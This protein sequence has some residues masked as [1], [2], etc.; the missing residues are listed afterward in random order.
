MTGDSRVIGIIGGMGPAATVEFM[1][2]VVRR[3]DAEDDDGHFRMLVDNNPKVPSRI[4]AIIEGT[5]ADPL[6][7]LQ[8]MAAGLE[9][10]G[11]DFLVMPCN[12]AHHYHRAIADAVGIPF[13]SIVDV[14][15][16]HLARHYPGA[17]RIGFLASPA[18][19]ETGVYDTAFDRHGLAIVYPDAEANAQL[20]G[21]IREIKAGQVGDRQAVG[22]RR[23]A[24]ALAGAADAIL[25][26]CTELS[27]LPL[28]AV[29]DMPVLD[30]L[31]LLVDA[32]IEAAREGSCVR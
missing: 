22:F 31:D 16:E 24:G 30:T 23:V 1:S 6:P 10:A 2:R 12:T 27:L 18:V 17:R 9:R 7:E 4:A 26:A 13:I 20:L 8:R 3:T 25:V 28:S 19:R 11:A 29:G 15:A 14:A 32:T 5:G 21:I